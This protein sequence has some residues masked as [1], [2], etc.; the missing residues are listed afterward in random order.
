MVRYLGGLWVAASTP[1]WGSYAKPGPVRQAPF[2]TLWSLRQWP[3]NQVRALDAVAGLRV[4]V[5]NAVL[6]S[7]DVAIK[8]SVFAVATELAAAVPA[9]ELRFTP[10]SSVWEEIDVRAV[11]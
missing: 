4:A 7:P 6:P 2:A 9:A 11:A 8:Q 1:F 3:T 5:D 10:D